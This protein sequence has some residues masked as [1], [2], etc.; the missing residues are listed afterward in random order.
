MER[1]IFTLKTLTKIYEQI[2]PIHSSIWDKLVG[3]EIAEKTQKFEVHTKNA[4]RL[5]APLVGRR[6][7]GVFI[8]KG[9]FETTIYEP[10]MLKLYTVNEAENMFE[11]KFGH[12]EWDNPEAAAKEE[13]AK[14]LVDLRKIA[15]RTKIWM[16]LVLATTGV[17]PVG[18]SAEIGIKYDADFTQEVLTTGEDFKNPDYDIVGY[19]EKKQTDIYKETGKVIDTIIMAPDV[20]AYFMKNKSVIEDQKTIN[21]NLVQLSQKVENLSEGM[22]LVAFLPRINMTIYS[23]IDWAKNPDDDTEEQ[24]LPAGTLIGLKSKSFIVRYGALALREKAGEKAKLFVRKEVVR[25][26][27]PE[28]SEDDELQLHSS[29]LIMPEDAKGYFC[30][31]VIAE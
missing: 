14:E 11:Q 24:L 6:E 3:E 2:K 12:T 7:K 31:K 13:L 28:G 10:P 19:F 1:N 25:T 22:K 17:C 8:A 18:E 21:S 26:W 30:A 9:A 15:M 29:P 20:V 5:K 27:Y 4:G 23:Y 16:L